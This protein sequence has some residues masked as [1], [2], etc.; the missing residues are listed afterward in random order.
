MRFHRLYGCTIASDLDLHL[1]EVDICLPPEM[2]LRRSSHSVD[3]GWWPKPADLLAQ[4]RDEISGTSYLASRTSQGYRVRFDGLCEFDLSAGLTEV[5]WKLFTGG[6]PELASVVAVGALM[7]FRLLM[8]GHLVLHASAVHVR[9]HGLAFGGAKGMG[10]ST[11]ATLMCAGGATILT[12]D[13]ARIELNGDRA[14]LSPGTEESRL[15]PPSASLKELFSTP[16]VVRTTSDGRN[17]ISLPGWRNG[18]VALDALVIPMP[19]RDQTELALTPI[20]P[21]QALVLL[22]F[23]PPLPGWVHAEVLEQQFNQLA[24]LVE[25]VP[26]YLAAVPWGPP[27]RTEMGMQLLELLR[28]DDASGDGTVEKIDYR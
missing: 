8:S 6:D 26:V 14:L 7:A 12:D 10:K 13:V 19:S 16:R 24:D 23:F 27:F 25:R 28:W 11:M 22:G 15:R 1:P 2:T 9:S 21:A 4:S 18:P 3:V 20:S 17:A 5:T